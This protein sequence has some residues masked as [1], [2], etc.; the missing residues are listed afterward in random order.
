MEEVKIVPPQ[1]N[2]KE[3]EKRRKKWEEKST[4]QEVRPFDKHTMKLPAN[5][6]CMPLKKFMET[7]EELWPIHIP[8][9]NG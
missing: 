1:K 4:E 3:N 9:Y 2:V 8:Q 7:T 5:F 6:A